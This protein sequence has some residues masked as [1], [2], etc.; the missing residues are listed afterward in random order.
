MNVL[1]ISEIKNE[2]ANIEQAWQRRLQETKQR[3]EV[4]LIC[5]MFKLRVTPQH[6]L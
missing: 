1:Q 2:M 4:S 3:L 5:F 6:I